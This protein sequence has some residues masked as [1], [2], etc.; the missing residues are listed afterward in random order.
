MDIQTFQN[1]ASKLPSEMAILMRGPT[2]V[3][4]SFLAKA[5]AD[6]LTLPFLDVRLSTMS[7]GDVGGYPDLDGM[8]DTGVMTFC[9]PS[10]F[11]RA[12][13]EPVVLCLDELNRALI[14]VQQSA[15]QLILD[16]QLGNDKNGV[17]YTLHPDTRIVACVNTGAEYTVE[18][19]DPAL[20]RRFWVV[21]LAPTSD[22]FVKWATDKLNPATVDFIRNH[23]EH[24]RVD[25]G[26]VDPGTI[27]P[28]PASWHRLDTSLQHMGILKQEAANSGSFY[29]VASGFVGTEAAIAFTEFVK[30]YSE[31]ITA[32]DILDNWKSTETKVSD[33]TN[34]KVNGL[35]EKLANHCKDNSWTIGQ[36]KNVAAF[37]KALPGEM[38]VNL[39]NKISASQNLPNIQKLH[40]LIGQEVVRAVQ[41]GRNVK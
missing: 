22:D 33:L 32:E 14:G 23:P 2:G 18:D 28:N 40:K 36:S 7:E 27:C 35:I 8:K 10:W 34:S 16:R 30:N 21:D 26:E 41:G 15:F 29:S 19:M 25:P 4:K 24:L 12:C 37:A 3:G 38:M 9:M 13:Q 20:L 11:I 31:V 6:E 39:W 5:I 17:P 1:V